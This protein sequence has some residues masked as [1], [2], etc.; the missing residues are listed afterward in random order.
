MI[1]LPN[2]EPVVGSA[3]IAR[4]WERM[5]SGAKWK[6]DVTT[7]SIHVADHHVLER[8]RYTV[9]LEFDSAAGEEVTDN[10]YYLLL[11]RRT[12]DGWKL[13]YDMSVSAA[14]RSSSN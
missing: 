4:H 1:F 9:M 13:Q 10:G 2:R 11:W 7:D 14:R 6:V 5:F 3:E 8:G 12:D